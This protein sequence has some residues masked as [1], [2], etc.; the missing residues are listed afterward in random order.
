MTVVHTDPEP[1]GLAAIVGGLIE[2]NLERDPSRRGL[3]RPAGIGIAAP[4][5]GV[6][7]TLRIS[8]GRVE[9]SN[10]LVPP[11]H[12]LVRAT[13]GALMELTTVPLRFGLPDAFTAAGR[14]VLRD[15]LAGRIRVRG[16]LRH[17]RRMVRLNS[18]LSV[19]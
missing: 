12:L 4:D 15:L 16:M 3:L 11:L 5:A 17:P 14:S 9:V 2:A 8:P 7:I 10:G 19:A 1:N 13:S 18:L 6:A